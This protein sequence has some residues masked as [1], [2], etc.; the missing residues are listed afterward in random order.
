MISPQTVAKTDQSRPAPMAMRRPL[1]KLTKV[2]LEI[3][4]ETESVRKEA[5]YQY[6]N[7]WHNLHERTE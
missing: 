3:S 2:L 4:A 1:T 5:N 7:T 6:R